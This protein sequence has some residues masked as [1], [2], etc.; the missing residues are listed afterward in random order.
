MK[1]NKCHFCCMMQ[2]C[3]NNP[4]YCDG[5]FKNYDTGGFKARLK[6]TV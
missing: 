2:F 6:L 1:N 5:E 3:V 4:S